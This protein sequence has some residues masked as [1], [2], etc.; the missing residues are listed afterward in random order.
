MLLVWLLQRVDLQEEVPQ[1]RVIHVAGT[2]GKVCR[3]CLQRP[4]VCSSCFSVLG[5]PHT[6]ALPSP[7]DTSHR[8]CI[9]QFSTCP[10]VHP[11]SAMIVHHH[12]DAVSNCL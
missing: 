9:P 7:S 2:K 12:S 3:T 1:L 4:C 11:Y 5:A 10:C 6:T 8:V